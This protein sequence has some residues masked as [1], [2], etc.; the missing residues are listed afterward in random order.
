ML[1]VGID[2][3]MVDIQNFKSLVSSQGGMRSEQIKWVEAAMG[4][5]FSY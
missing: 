5:A 1:I 4:C 3:F 2:D